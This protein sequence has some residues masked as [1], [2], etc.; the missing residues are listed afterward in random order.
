MAF[1]HP[2]VIKDNGPNLSK[3]VQLPTRIGKTRHIRGISSHDD[4][5]RLAKANKSFLDKIRMD[6]NLEHCRTDTGVAQKVHDKGSLEIG[7]TNGPHKTNIDEIFHCSPCFLNGGPALS[8]F[9]FEVFPSGRVLYIWIDVF[10]GNWEMHVEDIEVT[11]VNEN[12][13]HRP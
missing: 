11:S 6:L 3:N 12:K 8:Y 2:R 1:C 7:D 9:A 10:K 4:V 13:H 5:L